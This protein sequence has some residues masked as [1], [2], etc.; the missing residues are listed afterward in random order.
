MIKKPSQY[1]LCVKREKSVFCKR[2]VEY[3]GHIIDKDRKRPFES[4]V[5]SIKQLKKPENVSEV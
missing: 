3:L 4:S 5:T 1:G 2:L